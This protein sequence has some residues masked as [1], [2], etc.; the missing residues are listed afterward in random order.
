MSEAKEK[1]RIGIL[2]G[3]HIG[4]YED[5]LAKGGELISHISENLS[6]KYKV[7]DILIDKEGIWY[8]NGLPILPVDLMHRVDVVWNTAH[9]SFQNILKDFSIPNIGVT[10]FSKVVGD[11][12]EMLQEHMKKIGVEMPRHI[13][14]PVYQKDFDGPK[15]KYVNKKARE[16]LEKFGAPWIVKSFNPDS[17]IGVHI[18]KTFPELIDAI[19]DIVSHSDSVLVEELIS[20]K[21]AF[22]HTVGGFRGDLPTQAG[23]IYVF[24][25]L[26]FSKDEKEKLIKMAKNIHNHLG[27]EYYLKS[28]FVVNN[29]KGIFLTSVEFSPDLK[30]GSHFCKACIS[31]G[32]KSHHV[33]E[34]ILKLSF[35]KK[36]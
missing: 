18:A 20:G 17:N 7:V 5:S 12:R 31:V 32:A 16:V 30:K 26:G 24:P 10:P 25:P 36:E 11:S 8:I 27:I 9:S 2:R 13:I 1:K 35:N 34:H 23:D 19:A 6:D 4:N 14:F 15:E 22:M 28:N 21:N 3:G 29:K 33:L